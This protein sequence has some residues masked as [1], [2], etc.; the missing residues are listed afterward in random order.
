MIS[1]FLR[2]QYL[3]VH[4]IAPDE[5]FLNYLGFLERNYDTDKASN[6]LYMLLTILSL[7]NYANTYKFLVNA[8]KFDTQKVYE[9]DE[10]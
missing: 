2:K 1:T 5:K 9:Q 6:F 7:P 3:K 10:I 4:K 8:K